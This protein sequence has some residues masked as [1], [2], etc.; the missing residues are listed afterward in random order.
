MEGPA[1]IPAFCSLSLSCFPANKINKSCHKQSVYYL[2]QVVLIKP[3]VLVILGPLWCRPS[4]LGMSHI[5]LLRW[6]SVC[7]NRTYQSWPWRVFF[8]GIVGAEWTGPASLS[9]LRN[10]FT[11]RQ[12]FERELLN[13]GPKKRSRAECARVKSRDAQISRGV[14]RKDWAVARALITWTCTS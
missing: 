6:L 2:W 14:T 10:W 1:T 8:F 13:S 4:F 7:C 9:R 3:C 5:N 11:Q 12:S